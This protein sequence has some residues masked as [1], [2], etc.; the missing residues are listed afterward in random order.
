[1]SDEGTLDLPVGKPSP[2]QTATETEKRLMWIFRDSLRQRQI[3]PLL[4]ILRRYRERA[5]P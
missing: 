2:A 5:A 4:A 1:M 3:H